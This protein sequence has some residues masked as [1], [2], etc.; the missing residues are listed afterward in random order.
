[1]ILKYINNYNNRLEWEIN[2]MEVSKFQVFCKIGDSLALNKQA[3]DSENKYHKMT[4]QILNHRKDK[5]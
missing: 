5:M 3:K 1:M 4:L 2:Q